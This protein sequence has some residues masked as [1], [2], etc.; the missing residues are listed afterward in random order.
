[1]H[2]LGVSALYGREEAVGLKAG[3]GRLRLLR[4]A[5]VLEGNFHPS[6]QEKRLWPKWA[7]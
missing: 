6:I 7:L 5:W 4:L 1:M 2:C 3:P